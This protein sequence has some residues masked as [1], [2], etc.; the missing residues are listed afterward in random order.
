[1]WTLVYLD[2]FDDWLED[3]EINLQDEVDAALGLLEEFGPSLGRPRVDTLCDSKLP[4]LKELRI[5]FKGAPIR[6]LFVF[7]PKRQGVIILGG[8]KSGDERWYKRNI[9]VAENL[10]AVYLK[11]QNEDNEQKK[12]GK[13]K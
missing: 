6:I 2:E 10:Y 3:Q 13:H 7:D 12:K 5:Q 1:M 9:P 11:A 4:N 8:D